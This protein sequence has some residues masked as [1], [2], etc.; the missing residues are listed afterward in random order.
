MISQVPATGQ[1]LA[2]RAKTARSQALSLS[3]E[4][5]IRG[6][7]FRSL[8]QA[9]GSLSVDV[10]AV[11]ARLPP[12]VATLVNGDMKG[13]GWYPIASYAALHQAALDVSG[14]P[15]SFSR[16]V[17]Q[18]AT[19]LDARG[20]FQFVLR[21]VS[22]ESLV[23]HA[24]RVLGLYVEGSAIDVVLLGP[25]RGRVHISGAYG[26]TPSIW[27]DHWGTMEALVSLSGGVSP[28]AVEIER[29]D[30][31]GVVEMTWK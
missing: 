27:E 16:V 22:P 6:Q 20:V 4:A 21:F 30:D 24:D 28:R 29:G 25:N 7:A 11:V 9:L 2:A 18:Q 10:E 5:R 15:V 8:L 17:G 12:E 1:T 13:T 14:K 23:R 3:G 19:R 26:Y 31:W